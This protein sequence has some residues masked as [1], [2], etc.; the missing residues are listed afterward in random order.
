MTV[1]KS[2]TP[3][4]VRIFTGHNDANQLTGTENDP[5]GYI[6]LEGKATME[7]VRG[8]CGATLFNK[9]PDKARIN[10]ASLAFDMTANIFTPCIVNGQWGRS[11]NDNYSIRLYYLNAKDPV[12]KRSDE[13]QDDV[14]MPAERKRSDDETYCTA[15][16]GGPPPP[17]PVECLM[18]ING[19]T[20]MHSPRSP[21]RSY[22][23]RNHDANR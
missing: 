16:I 13:A 6:T 18:A 23:L 15:F 9:L 4:A 7:I 5:S 3:S 14:Q 19:L 12:S 10:E 11:E 17:V 22:A 1:T 21:A 2:L 8:L 20:S